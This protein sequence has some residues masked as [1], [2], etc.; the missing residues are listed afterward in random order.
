MNALALGSDIITA[1]Y[2]VLNAW[3]EKG[4]PVPGQNFRSEPPALKPIPYRRIDLTR[5]WERYHIRHDLTDK[6]MEKFS[7][8]WNALIL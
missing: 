7:A 6:G 2:E 1:P 3:A 8:D 5:D 4:L